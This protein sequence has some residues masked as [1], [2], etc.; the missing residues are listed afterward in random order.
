MMM[1]K[2]QKKET[3]QQV[4]AARPGKIASWLV[5]YL[6]AGEARLS[7]RQKLFFLV[8]FFLCGIA[9]CLHIAIQSPNSGHFRLHDNII[10]PLPAYQRSGKELEWLH[11][12][13][14]FLDSL[15]RDSNGVKIYEQMRMQRPG[16]LDTIEM[17]GKIINEQN[18]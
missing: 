5:H 1:W 17:A 14:Q 18:Y 11:R 4:T 15:K 13:N 2:K 10:P 8:L 9:F 3:E 6:Q 7:R 16:L 12:Y